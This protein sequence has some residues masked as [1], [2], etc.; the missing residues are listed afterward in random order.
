MRWLS[1]HFA[2]V[3]LQRFEESRETGLSCYLCTQTEIA[4][5]TLEVL[6]YL[7]VFHF[8][9]FENHGFMDNID[10]IYYTVAKL[11]LRF[12]WLIKS[13]PRLVAVGKVTWVTSHVLPII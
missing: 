4:R 1:W 13:G 7:N 9:K 10:I 11:I 3:C 2:F 5:V 8:L 6:I 12:F